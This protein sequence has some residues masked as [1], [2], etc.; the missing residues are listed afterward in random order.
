MGTE[1]QAR[2][3]VEHAGA[4]LPGLPAQL[5]WL[6]A[7]AEHAQAAAVWQP[8][9]GQDG[10]RLVWVNRAYCELL[11]CEPDEVL[12]AKA[13]HRMAEEHRREVVRRVAEQVL[14]GGTAH[15]EIAL[16]RTDGSQI[17]VAGTYFGVLG[18]APALV[19]TYRD[20]SDRERARRNEHWAETILSRGHDLLMVTDGE[21]VLGFVS[22]PV[23]ET[24]GYQPADLLGRSILDLVH[25][26]DL[27]SAASDFAG[28]VEGTS[29]E[30]P[31][32]VRARHA[33][34]SWLH[35]EAQATVLLDDPAVGGVLL[36]V[37]DVTSQHRAERLAAEHAELLEGVARGMPLEATL[38]RIAK[39]IERNLPHVRSTVGTV[40]A[41]GVIRI[42]VAPSLDREL[43]RCIDE[44][45]PG[46]S[47]GRALRV[48]GTSPVYFDR[49]VTDPRWGPLG[50]R[51]DE[52]GIQACWVMRIANPGTGEM[53]GDIGV[54]LPESRLPTEEE[55]LLLERAT[56]LAAVA[57]ERREFESALEHQALH[58][59]L[60]GLPNRTLLLDRIDQALARNRRLGHRLAVLFL[61]LDGFK[62]INDSLGH[63]AGDQLLRQVATR[64]AQAVRDGDTV[65]RFGGDEFL[66]LCEEIDDE[67]GAVAVADRLAQALELPLQVA[68]SE[69]FVRASIGVAL[70]ESDDGST[71]AESLV[72]N[73]DVAMY[74]AK[75]QGRD[76]TALF[77][78]DL[79]RQVVARVDLERDLHRAVDEDQ[80][81]LHFQPIVRLADSSVVGTEA[82]VRW[83]RPGH[84]LVSPA[85]FIPLAE[86]TGLIIPIGRWVIEKA[87]AQAARW[88]DLPGG[89]LEMS[90]NLSGR[91]LAR[92]GFVDELEAIVG[93][94]G[95]DPTLLCFEVTESTL[96]DDE[97][98]PALLERIKALGARLAIDDFGT[99]YAT[100]DYVRRFSMADQLKIDRSFVAGIEDVRSPDV[101][102]VSAAIVL[103][104][105]LGFT[106]VAEGVE[107]DVQLGVLR[108]LGCERA[109]GFYFS[110]PVRA[111]ELTPSFREAGT[112]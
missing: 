98:L 24:M 106:V 16:L 50:P 49:I 23:V 48:E 96:A 91:Q 27:E 42:V 9:P 86:D 46:S 44:V 89:P 14:A 84:G 40:D 107:T 1:M 34:G 5:A 81:V 41:D 12:G 39:L 59:E 43:V 32:V 100:L 26:D 69:A 61:D 102:I 15:E 72:R 25:P 68:D 7:L 73:A 13:G 58:D 29:N 62:L 28:A 57:I 37:R 95:V 33:D 79:H 67:A 45:T 99:G 64:F 22:P 83:E 2:D 6:E 18:D 20:L 90:I 19:G 55:R 4:V 94:S 66:V 31:T 3:V 112:S 78:E 82:L 30:T 104:N 54:Y 92:P 63:A 85:E 87:C 53:L 71:T 21:G 77:E 10:I 75:A 51:F 70:A 101:A 88:S 8:V 11:D 47:L 93:A 38:F 105:A 56:S 111:R 65:G 60:T 80:L 36:T 108:G 17:L 103:A 52:A 110:R 97:G 35:L 109:Q 76:R 74:R